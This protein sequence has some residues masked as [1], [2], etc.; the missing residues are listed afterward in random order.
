MKI[1][2]VEI[3]GKLF[4]APMSNVTS[5]PFRLLCKRYGAAMVYSEMI[6]ADAFIMGS[7]KTMKRTYFL[8]FER[9]IGI[10]LSGSDEDKLKRAIIKAEKELMPDIIDIN[11]GCPA[12]TVMKSGCGASLLED[13]AKLSRIVSLLSG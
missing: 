1:G 13:T 4:L 3:K 9:P 7:E 10:Q 12:Y 6:N 2:T 8:D 11:I 5:L